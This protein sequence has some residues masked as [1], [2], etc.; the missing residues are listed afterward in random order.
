M[1]GVHKV[2]AEY[3]LSW[4]KQSSTQMLLTKNLKVLTFSHWLD[5]RG[6]LRS[7]HLL[8][9]IASLNNILDSKKDRA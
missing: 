2:N 3:S 8:E 1:R 9:S 4:P 6:G 7:K 5:T